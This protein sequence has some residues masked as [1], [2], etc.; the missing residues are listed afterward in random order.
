MHVYSTV[1]LFS[2]SLTHPNTCC[3]SA[4]ITCSM[5][6]S[7][8]TY[9]CF[10]CAPL[11][12]HAQLPFLEARSLSQTSCINNPFGVSGLHRCGQ[13]KLE[14]GYC[15]GD[16]CCRN[17]TFGRAQFN[18]ICEKGCT[19]FQPTDDPLRPSVKC[20]GPCSIV[21]KCCA[22]PPAG[23]RFMRVTCASTGKSFETKDMSSYWTCKYTDKYG[24]LQ[25][26]EYDPACV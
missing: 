21:V 13:G 22:D 3:V 9:A 6:V 4:E 2:V 8:L 1:L 25:E 7:P 26:T 20:P 23:S 14:A 18:W 11:L 10:V 12:Q 16:S 19:F 15:D 5:L 24:Y 17:P